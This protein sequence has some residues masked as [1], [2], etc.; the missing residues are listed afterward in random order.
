MRRFLVAFAAALFAASAA[1]AHAFLDH[2]SPAAGSVVHAPPVALQLAF[3]NEVEPAHCAVSL[4]DVT[5]NA[6]P[7]GPLS[8]SSDNSVLTAQIRTHLAPGAYQVHWRAVSTEGH[9]TSGS[10]AFRVN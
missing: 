10:F 2:A 5:G 6:V 8:A 7:L 1:S 3:D 9:T 4:T